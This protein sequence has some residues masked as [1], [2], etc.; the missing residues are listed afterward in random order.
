MK[1]SEIAEKHGLSE[2]KR[3]LFDEYTRNRFDGAEEITS[4]DTAFLALWERIV[5]YADMVGA[6]RA[7][8]DKI[9]PKRPV[10]FNSP[11][12][13]KMKMYDSAAGRIPVIYVRDTDDVEQLG[14]NGA[15]KGEL[16]ENISQ[17]GASFIHGKQTRLIILSAKPYSN[18]PASELGLEDKND[19]AE[20][21]LILRQD[22]EC[23]H[24]FT[25][26]TYGITN[27]ILHDEIMADFIGIYEAF[28]FYRAEWFLRFMGII[29]GSGNR[30]EVYTKGLPENVCRAVHDLAVLSAKG[31]EGWSKSDGFKKMTK[32]ERIKYMCKEGLEGF[33]NL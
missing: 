22:H 31:L 21:S 4:P 20:R 32:A 13:L 1:F 10:S 29:P 11:E 26:Q 5:F 28:G 25:K 33:I 8:N 23:T 16:P 7:I 17:T 6:D 30:S 12:T 14:T 27:N 9:C 24:Y 18:V 15:Y 3:I 2:E 19:W